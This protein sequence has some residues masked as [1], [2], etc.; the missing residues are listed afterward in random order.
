MQDF[1][2]SIDKSIYAFFNCFFANSFCDWFFMFITNGRNWIIPLMPFVIVYIV[3][4]RKKALVVI[5]LA[6]LTIAISDPLSVRIIKPLV[7][8]LRP[9]DPSYFVNGQHIFL[10]CAHFLGGIRD[11]LSFPSAHAVNMFAQATLFTLFY[12]KRWI[13]FFTIATL[14]GIS[15][16]YIGIHY[17]SDVIGGALIGAGIGAVVFYVYKRRISRVKK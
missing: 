5:G 1:L 7:H 15:R 2:F 9:C 8:R 14:I 3:K 16:I 13:I 4:A 17:P 11:S 12:P 10:P 6:L